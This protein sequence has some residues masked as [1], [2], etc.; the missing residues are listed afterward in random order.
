MPRE[1]VYQHQQPATKI[2]DNYMSSLKRR[3]VASVLES[4]EESEVRNSRVANKLS[5][6]AT[7][8]N[9][10]LAAQKKSTPQ[11]YENRH[12]NPQLIMGYTGI[13]QR[14]HEINEYSKKKN[15]QRTFG[16][17]FRNKHV[18]DATQFT[19]YSE[20]Q[21]EGIELY[22]K[23]SVDANTIIFMT[24]YQQTLFEEQDHDQINDTTFQST[25]QFPAVDVNSQGVPRCY[26]AA[27]FKYGAIPKL[28]GSGYE[29]NHMFGIVSG[30]LI[31]LPKQ[32][33]H[34]VFDDDSSD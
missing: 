5:T 4:Q 24:P 8:L 29:V 2:H 31:E 6:C 10:P 16:S 1:L 12:L 26:S 11:E 28:D 30:S 33:T 21:K 13:M 27:K 23:R 32:N 18:R 19:S 3:A 25:T 15:K 14:A 20:M 7:F 17:D 9:V 34:I 22:K